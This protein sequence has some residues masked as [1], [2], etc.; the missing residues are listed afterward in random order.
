MNARPNGLGVEETLPRRHA[1]RVSKRSKHQPPHRR[2][3]G[4]IVLVVLIVL[5]GLGLTA[6][7]QQPGARTSPVAQAAETNPP[8]RPASNDLSSAAATTNRFD[9]AAFDVWLTN[10]INVDLL[11]STGGKMLEENDP[12]LGA[13]TFLR[14]VE[15]R[16]DNEEAWFNL[17]VAQARLG[18]LDEAEYSYHRAITNFLEYTEARNNLGNL[19]TRQKRYA[20]AA[21]Q[22]N[23]VLEQSPDNAAAHNNLGRVLAAQGDSAQA[24]ERFRTAARLDTNYLEARFNIGSALL[25]MGQ[26]NE[27]VAAFRETLRLRPD[28][29][30]ALS[31]LAKLRRQP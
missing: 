24:L 27:A 25:V 3:G 7:L 21:E 23:T 18:L 20:E 13:L 29:P 28:F 5:T 22:F 6:W 19:L 26:T 10:E 30:P 1:R 31:A 2:S 14:A 16:P 8:A 9:R 17:G 15:L 4:W 12:K 11:M